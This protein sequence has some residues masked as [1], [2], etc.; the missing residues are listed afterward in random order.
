M[1][2]L[3]RQIPPEKFRLTTKT[4]RVATVK[5]AHELLQEK[6]AI[7]KAYKPSDIPPAS[8][9]PRPPFWGREL[10]RPTDLDLPTICRYINKNALFRGQWGFKQGQELT[11]DQWQELVDREAEPVFKRWI[12][13]ATSEKMLEPQAAYGWW[14]AASQQNDLIVFDPATGAEVARFNLPR[15]MEPGSGHKCLADYLRPLGAPALGDEQSWFPAAAWAAGARDVIG[16]SCVTMGH[17]ASQHCQRLFKADNYQE[18]LYF[19]G[20]SVE[21]AEGLA[22]YWHK[23]MRQQLNISQHDAADIA[24]LFTQGYQGSRY[25]FG[26]PACPNLDDQAHLQRLLRWEDIG[27][28]LSEEFQL[29]PEQST[30]ALV[31]HHPAARYFSL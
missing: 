13:K 17:V 10:V 1:D 21:A 23:R 29:D 9:I 3:C 30:S 12:A 7:G 14:P 28:H 27:I 4:A 22:E 16:F 20:L 15:Q 5:T 8:V 6:L 26:Y 24:D 2:E 11:K 25:S 18:Y 31:F 19:Y